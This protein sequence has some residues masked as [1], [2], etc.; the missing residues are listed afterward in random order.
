LYQFII[1]AD[2]LRL[3][4]IKHPEAAAPLSITISEI[5]SIILKIQ[6]LGIISPNFFNN[7]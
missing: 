4:N 6:T 3:V 1:R 5:D 2:E 7:V